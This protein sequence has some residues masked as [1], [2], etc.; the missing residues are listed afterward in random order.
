M[1]RWKLSDSNSS[2]RFCILDH[3]TF[4]QHHVI[5]GNRLQKVNIIPHNVVGG[6][7]D[8]V[9]EYVWSHGSSHAGRAHVQEGLQG[10]GEF[11]YFV[12]PVSAYSGGTHD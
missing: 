3:V 8:V 2:F 5:P 9:V 12:Q 10:G 11:A 6:D 1:L 4:V 7:D